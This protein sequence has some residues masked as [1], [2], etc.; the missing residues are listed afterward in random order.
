MMNKTNVNQYVGLVTTAES[1]LQQQLATAQ[2][3]V[4]NLSLSLQSKQTLLA[5]SN[6][7]LN[8]YLANKAISDSNVFT[9][10]T[11]L[12]IAEDN[13]NKAQSSSTNL[14][15]QIANATNAYKIAVTSFSV[16]SAGKQASDNQ[17]Q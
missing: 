4:A 1:T 6:N 15:S 10:K 2:Q 14:Q 5:N 16:A 12:G 3:A 17:I 9:L 13:F 8:Q 7:A 11:Q